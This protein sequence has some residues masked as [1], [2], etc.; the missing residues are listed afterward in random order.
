LRFR[1]A[2][3]SSVIDARSGY[4]LVARIEISSRIVFVNE[5]PAPVLTLGNPAFA[6]IVVTRASA[7]AR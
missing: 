6:D 4:A 7:E 2:F 5:R 1:V 3:P